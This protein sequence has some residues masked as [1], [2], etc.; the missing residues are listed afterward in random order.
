MYRRSLYI[1]NLTYCRFRDPSFTT[2]KLSLSNYLCHFP[3]YTREVWHYKDSNDDLIR[4]A[5]IQFNCES[6][7]KNKNVDE[8]V[9][10]FNKIVLNI[11]CNFILCELIVCDDKDP[12]W[13][14][15]NI[16][17]LIHEKI[18]TYK[19]LRKNISK[20]NISKLRN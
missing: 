13:F 14:N 20:L 4:R 11:L 9:L 19:V 15:I 8:K 2:S 16:K 1:Q 17:P 18:K 5:I 10:T 12:P 3:P 7:F 6:A